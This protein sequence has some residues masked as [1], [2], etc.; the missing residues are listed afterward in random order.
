[1]AWNPNGILAFSP[2]LSRACEITS[3]S[4]QPQFFNRTAVA[5]FHRFDHHNAVDVDLCSA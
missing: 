5:A 4:R 3:G 1:V 2:R